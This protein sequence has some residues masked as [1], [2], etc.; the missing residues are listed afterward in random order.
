[1]AHDHRKSNE[2]NLQTKTKEEEKYFK[3]KVVIFTVQRIVHILPV[4]SSFTNYFGT[5]LNLKSSK[6]SVKMEKFGLVV[7]V[8]RPLLFLL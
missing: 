7:V 6:Y 2:R 4:S 3:E 1:M 8:I 5:L